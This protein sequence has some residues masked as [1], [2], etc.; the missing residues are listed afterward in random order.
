MLAIYFQL[1]RREIR[2]CTNGLIA[3]RVAD[4]AKR[5]LHPSVRHDLYCTSGYGCCMLHGNGKFSFQ[6]DS[7]NGALIRLSL[8][9]ALLS[10]LPQKNSKP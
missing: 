2:V 6:M 9:D 3:I 4:L 10:T 1:R 5:T 7:F 8:R